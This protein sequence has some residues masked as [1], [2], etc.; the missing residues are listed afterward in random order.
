MRDGA[1]DAAT[2]L[3]QRL[4]ENALLQGLGCRLDEAEPGYVELSIPAAKASDGQ[5]IGAGAVAALAEAAARLALGGDGETAELSL[6]LHGLGAASG[7][8]AVIARGEVLRAASEGRPLATAQA[9][10][11]RVDAGGGEALLAT[12][13]VTILRPG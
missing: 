12:A 5:H 9:D 3:S 11:F 13:L 4:N 6:H 2:E 7:A 8:E 10:V 1:A